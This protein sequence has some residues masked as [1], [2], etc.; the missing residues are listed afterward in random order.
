MFLDIAGM[1]QL[2]AYD[3]DQDEKSVQFN[4]NL[5]HVK[6]EDVSLGFSPRK[7]SEVIFMYQVSQK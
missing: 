5:P 6:M 1:N 3:Y 7:V 4:I 2:P